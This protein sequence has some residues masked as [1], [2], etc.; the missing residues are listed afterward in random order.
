MRLLDIFSRHPHGDISAHAD[1]ELAS[2]RR[3]ALEAHI[4]GCERCRTEL[5][6]LLAVQSALRDLP[7]AEATRSFALTPAMAEREPQP[8]ASR[9]VPSFVAMRVAGAGF[10]ADLA[11]VVMLDAGGIVDNSGGGS[12]GESSTALF[13]AGNR[14][15]EATTA[16]GAQDP[17]S[18]PSSP[19]GDFGELDGSPAADD[20]S[21]IPGAGAGAGSSPDGLEDVPDDDLPA[22]G[23][24]VGGP[25]GSEDAPDGGVVD[26]ALAPLPEDFGQVPAGA[27]PALGDANN[28]YGDDGSAAAPESGDAAPAALTSEDDGVSWLLVIEIGLAAIAVL[29]VGGSFVMRRRE[30]KD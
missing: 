18:A 4:A 2:G 1:G 3:E 9:A 22:A 8:V 21:E 27:T 13:D 20:G 28:L 29:A 6:E 26:P 15:A 16:A 30:E 12:S 10:A 19:G 25:D 24:G 17:F 11:I 5:G 7:Q 23:G 14:D